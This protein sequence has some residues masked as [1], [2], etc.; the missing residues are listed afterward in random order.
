[1]SWQAVSWAFGQHLPPATKLVLVSIAYCADKYGNNAYPG[2]QSI[3]DDASMSVR[4]VQRHTEWLEKH[5]YL[6]RERRNR[7]NGTRTSDRYTLHMPLPENSAGRRQ[8]DSLSPDNGGRDNMTLVSGLL[9][10]RGT[11]S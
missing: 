11:V 9:T 4:S 7:T 5:G 8:P 6:T 2:Q 1:M 10:V 3:A